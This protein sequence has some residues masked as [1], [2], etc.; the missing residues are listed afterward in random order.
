MRIL[1]KHSPL[2]AV[3]FRR[4]FVGAGP[5]HYGAMELMLSII[6]AVGCRLLR[7]LVTVVVHGTVNTRLDWAGGDMVTLPFTSHAAAASSTVALRC[8]LEWGFRIS[9]SSF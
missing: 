5:E 2:Q 1:N 4:L 8:E 6:V 7:R 9:D 3:P